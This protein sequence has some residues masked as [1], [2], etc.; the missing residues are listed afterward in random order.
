MK[1][2]LKSYSLF[3]VAVVAVLLVS[4]KPSEPEVDNP[5]AIVIDISTTQADKAQAELLNY[6]GD[7]I[8]IMATASY[9][10]GKFVLNLPAEVAAA[11]LSL[12]SLGTFDPRIA[13]SNSQARVGGLQISAYKGNILVGF[14]VMA[15][16]GQ[17]SSKEQTF[18]YADRD[19]NVLGD[20]QDEI[21]EGLIF[22]QIYEMQL[23]KGWNK[24]YAIN[25]NT[26]TVEG[27]QSTLRMTTS[28]Q[29]GLRWMIVNGN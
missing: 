17:S 8:G 26:F 29:A 11:N 7:L 5:N 27:M 2:Y 23:K 14:F 15:D 6:Q 4:C 21:F 16:V 3:V 24:V 10:N 19:V 28:A 22:R 18:I 9:K 25:S 20:Y 13:V 1:P 12:A